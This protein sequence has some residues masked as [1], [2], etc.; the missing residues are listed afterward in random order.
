M[1]LGTQ[2]TMRTFHIGGTAQVV[3][4]SFIEASFE[5][6]VKIRN[7]NMHRDSDGRMIAM[8]R[9]MAII[10]EDN[11]GG[12]LASHRVTYGSRMHVDDGDTVKQSQRMSE[13]DPYTRPILT[14]VSGIVDF[15]DVV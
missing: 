7:R 10:I 1:N 4:S 2:L 15:E 11:K 8:G 13:W 6:T 14:E 3:D 12:E 5:G 9:N